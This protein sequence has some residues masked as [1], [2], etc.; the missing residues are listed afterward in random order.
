MCTLKHPQ[1]INHELT[2]S[3]LTLRERENYRVTSNLQFSSGGFGQVRSACS[4]SAM[5]LLLTDASQPALL[6]KSTGWDLI[7]FGNESRG[8]QEARQAPVQDHQLA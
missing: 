2:D 3:R 8:K 7:R 5:R 1:L 6:H 4:M